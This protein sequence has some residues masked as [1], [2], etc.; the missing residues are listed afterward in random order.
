MNK[1]DLDILLNK[2]YN[3]ET[4]LD[5]EKLLHN[6]LAGDDA[7]SM[8]MRAL[9]QVGND[10]EVPSDLE[11]SLNGKIDE[12]Q[13]Q[14]Q[15]E[16]KVTS[17]IWGRASWWAVAASVAVLAAAAGWWLMRDN[18]QQLPGEQKQAVL[19]ENVE[20]GNDMTITQGMDTQEVLPKH[21]QAAEQ[22]K[23]Q[24]L[25]HAKPAS[26]YRGD[27]ERLAQAKVKPQVKSKRP[28]VKPQAEPVLTPSEEE[29]A[30]EALEK[31]SKTLNK[32]MGQ[33]DNANEKINAINNTI[34]QHLL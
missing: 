26:A 11:S 34:Q 13:D 28:Q 22:H 32:G 1:K 14:E 8:L 9:E 10:V 19:A 27:V 33:I 6:A 5:E 29:M 21:E 4:T 18:S 17:S 25:P 3:G 7:D 24:S 12:W 15:Q 20:R 31:F 30:I 23:L 2:F 16:D